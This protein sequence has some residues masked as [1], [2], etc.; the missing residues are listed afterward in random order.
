MCFGDFNL[1]LCDE[2]KVG[3]KRGSGSTPNL[4]QEIMFE[5]GAVDLGFTGSNFTWCNK[6]WGRGCI[7]Q[8]LDRGIAN[9]HWRL[10]FPRV[11]IYHLGAV[12]SNH[13]PLLIDSNLEDCLAPR[14]FRFKAMW[15]KDPRCYDVIDGAWQVNVNGLACFRLYRKQFNTIVAL[16]KW[17]KKIF[18]HCQSRIAELSHKIEHI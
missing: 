2:E 10:A 3:G 11:A 6:R 9:M 7:R 1:T 8:R 5:F 15:A 14:S 17:N 12:N 4:L 16:N 18:G 13:N